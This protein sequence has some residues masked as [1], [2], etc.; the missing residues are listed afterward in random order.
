MKTLQANPDLIAL[1]ADLINANPVGCL[2]G[3]AVVLAVLC[4]LKRELI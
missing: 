2:Y 1:A 3:A 4:A